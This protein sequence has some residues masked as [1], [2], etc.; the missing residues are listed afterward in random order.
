[1]NPPPSL[2]RCRARKT[3]GYFRGAVAFLLEVLP[4]DLVDLGHAAARTAFYVDGIYSMTS[5]V[6][7]AF[8][9]VSVATHYNHDSLFAAFFCEA[10]KLRHKLK[11]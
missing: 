9:A 11:R 1:M 4:P 7:V 5:A 2:L 3:H 6:T 8:D 10:F